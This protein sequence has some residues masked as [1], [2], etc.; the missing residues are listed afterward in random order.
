MNRAGVSDVESI[1]H[2]DEAREP[3]LD[4]AYVREHPADTWRRV[5]P[6]A[7]QRLDVLR[8]ATHE[9]AGGRLEEHLHAQAARS[10]RS[11]A[12]GLD[13]LGFEEASRMAGIVEGLLAASPLQPEDAIRLRRLTAQIEGALGTFPMRVS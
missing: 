1:R 11:L 4:P 7:E 8:R 12:G 9:L 10:A 6:L 5:R 13:L 3:E 2:S